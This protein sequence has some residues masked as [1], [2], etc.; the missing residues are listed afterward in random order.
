MDLLLYK[1]FESVVNFKVDPVRFEQTKDL[2]KSYYNSTRTEEPSQQINTYLEYILSE[3]ARSSDEMVQSFNGN[4]IAA[5][6]L[7]F[8]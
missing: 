1:I 4:Y 5:S 2:F 8:V 3:K 6:L 7:V